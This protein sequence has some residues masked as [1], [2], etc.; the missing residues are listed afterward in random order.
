MAGAVTDFFGTATV[1]PGDG[2]PRELGRILDRNDDLY[3]NNGYLRLS[4]NTRV[5]LR[6]IIENPPGSGTPNVVTSANALPDDYLVRGDGVRTVQT[7]SLQTTGSNLVVPNDFYA[8]DGNDPISLNNVLWPQTAPTAGQVLRA[9]GATTTGWATPSA[10]SLQDVQSAGGG[11]DTLIATTPVTAGVVYLKD[12]SGGTGITVTSDADDI[13]ISLTGGA[14]VTGSGTD[15]RLVLWNGT[16]AIDASAISEPTAGDLTSVKTINTSTPSNLSGNAATH[17]VAGNDLG[18]TLSTGTSNVTG[19]IVAGN[20][21]NGASTIA[22]NS[23]GIAILGN[24]GLTAT[25]SSTCFGVS[26]LGCTGTMSISTGSSTVGAASSYCTFAGGSEEK[27]IICSQAVQNTNFAN[28]LTMGYAASTTPSTANRTIELYASTGNGTI[29]GTLTQSGSLTDIA[30]YYENALPGII[31]PG[32]VVT[33]VFDGKNT[34]KPAEPGD[35]FLGV[36]SESAAII[37]NAGEFTWQ[38]RYEKT[39]HGKY[40]TEDK[41][42]EN[43]VPKKGQTEADRPIVKARKESKNYDPSKPY[44]ARSERPREW[45]C[46]ATYRGAQVFVRVESTVGI[47]PGDWLDVKAAGVCTKSATKS[48]LHVIKVVE[49]DLC[50]CFMD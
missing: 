30:E 1:T 35:H 16:T 14:G 7:T 29:E 49:P 44:V 11:G 17:F 33:L 41:F 9:T 2:R 43:W 8:G 38:G 39:K 18:S 48:R 21:I 25:V 50:W 5:D 23:A 32:T 40:I 31:P 46:I 47:A 3:M 42:K 24:S 12:I 26:Y 15:N 22:G 4:N 13:I 10:F 6:T 34:C 37:L 19:V 45:S 28:T 36:V 27:M 20:T